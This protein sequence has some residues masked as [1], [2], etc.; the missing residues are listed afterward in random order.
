MALAN[1]VREAVIAF[2]SRD[3]PRAY[4][5]TLPRLLREAGLVDVGADVF[6]SLENAHNTL[7]QRH[8]VEIRRANLVPAG[9][10]TDEEIDQH[11]ADLDPGL[12]DIA[13]LPIVSA[14]A[15]KPL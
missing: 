11:L 14:W 7:Y 4:G 1:K 3:R 5:R 9:L 10:L 15:R 12:V 2:S 6:F 13:S 8:M